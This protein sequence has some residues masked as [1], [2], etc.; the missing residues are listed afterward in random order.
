M[1][2]FREFGWVELLLIG[3]F[4]AFYVLYLSKII[5]ISRRLSTPY[6]TVFIKLFFRTCFFALLII[7]FLGPSFG[8]SKKEIKSVGKDIMI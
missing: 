3:L 5:R 4:V 1:V 6:K 2:W 8:G 7:S